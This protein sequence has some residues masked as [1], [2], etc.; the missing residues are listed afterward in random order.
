L[1]SNPSTAPTSPPKK[2]K[3]E[4][5]IFSKIMHEILG[6][7]ANDWIFVDIKSFIFTFYFVSLF[8]LIFTF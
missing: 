4:K 3:K 2:R 7:K 1:S 8:L 5:R 6:E